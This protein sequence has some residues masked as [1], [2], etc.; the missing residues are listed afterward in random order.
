MKTKDNISILIRI[1]FITPVIVMFIYGIFFSPSNREE[2]I[3]LEINGF[4]I[5][6]YIDSSNHGLK[7]IRVKE[8][9]EKTISELVAI[10]DTSFYNYLIVGDIITKAAKQNCFIVR[11][12]I[13]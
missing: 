5:D 7:T 9:K 3:E 1:F 8:L 6:K 13:K 11:R 12:K 2:F 10:G 4:V